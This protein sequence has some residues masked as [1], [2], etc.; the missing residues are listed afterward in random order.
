[1][2]AS[3]GFVPITRDKFVD[4]YAPPGWDYEMHGRPDY[5]TMALPQGARVEEIEE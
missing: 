2:Y 3:L 4:E 5:V 1:M